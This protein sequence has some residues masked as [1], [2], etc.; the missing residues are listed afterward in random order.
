MLLGFE[1]LGELPTPLTWCLLQM[2]LTTRSCRWWSPARR[3]RPPSR[4]SPSLWPPHVSLCSEEKHLFDNRT[5]PAAECTV[6]FV[7]SLA[8][9]SQMQVVDAKKLVILV[10]RAIHDCAA[11]PDAGAAGG[12]AIVYV[13]R[14]I[15]VLRAVLLVGR[16]RCCVTCIPCGSKNVCAC[17]IAGGVG[18]GPRPRASPGAG[19]GA[20][21]RRQW[22]PH[23]ARPGA[24]S[25]AATGSVCLKLI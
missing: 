25:L 22:R 21:R 5:S 17:R 15:F 18:A 11:R 19:G 1:S 12:K 4:S 16:S 23:R 10:C 3:R 20:G 9:L 7:T 13:L 6:T 8:V 14:A 2:Q 24:K